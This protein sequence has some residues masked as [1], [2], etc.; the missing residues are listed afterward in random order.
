MGTSMPLPKSPRRLLAPWERTRLLLAAAVVG[1][2]AGYGAVGFR[3]LIGLVQRVLWGDGADLLAG[4]ALR[5]PLLI[6]A[7]PALGGAVVAFL[8]SRFAN[9]ARGHGV[10]EVM[11]AVARRGGRIRP[12]VAIVKALA[13]SLTI[14]SG[15]SVGREGPI[16]QIGSAIGSTLGQLLE[17]RPSQVQTLLGCGAAAGIAATFNAPIAGA[18]FALELLLANFAMELFA[19]IVVSSVL[20]TIISRYHFGDISA[21][22][23]PAYEMVSAWEVL[24]YLGLGVV[25]G[26][27]GSLFVRM[28]YLAEDLA[29][30]VPLPVPVKGLASGAAVGTLA[31]FSPFVLGNGYETI[32]GILNLEVGGTGHDMIHGVLE[33]GGVFGSVSLA[34]VLMIV[35]KLVATSLTLGGGGSGGVFSPSLFIGCVTGYLFGL[36]LQAVAPGAVG[37]P[38]A[39]AVVAMS[40]MVAG[41]TLAPITAVVILFELTGDY[42]IILP[43][44]LTSIVASLVARAIREE[45]IYTLKLIRRGVRVSAGVEESAMRTLRVQDVMRTDADPLSASAPFDAIVGQL[46]SGGRSSAYIV[47]DGGRYAGSVRLRDV[48]PVLGDPPD[49]KRV[50]IAADLADPT[51]RPV[52]ADAALTDA[53]EELWSVGLDEM[54]VADA[55]DRLVGYITHRDVVG[56][57]NREVLHKQHLMARIVSRDA[58]EERTD[59]VELP[60]DYAIDQVEVPPTLDGAS[61]ADADLRR[62]HGINVLE[63]KTTEEGGRVRRLPPTVGRPLVAGELL[64]VVGK[65]DAIDRFRAEAGVAPNAPGDSPEMEAG[66]TSARPS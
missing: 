19:P 29:E 53:M 65:R 9:E 54:P 15:G 4:A 56:A 55:D 3:L 23:I 41:T 51:V 50:L 11:E 1:A 18:L 24:P 17:L 2:V 52:A 63:V 28:I 59:F 14:G 42:A 46:L 61:L 66:S 35:A 48:A 47:D 10:P 30:R 36:G 58:G 62:R 6:V 64:V 22:E 7:I 21:F 39:Y 20:A 57:Y 25:V 33:T 60:E 38:S 32:E 44:M 45:S 5:G 34:L 37:P 26:L 8:V 16:V 27:V 49:V 12:R 43:L 13:S 40:G 31:L